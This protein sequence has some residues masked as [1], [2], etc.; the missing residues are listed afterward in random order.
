MSK[1]EAI[2]IL[3]KLRNFDEDLLDAV[4]IES[5]EHKILAKRTLDRIRAFD[6]AIDALENQNVC[7]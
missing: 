6:I 1:A 2:D 4:K 5:N 3:K 7:D